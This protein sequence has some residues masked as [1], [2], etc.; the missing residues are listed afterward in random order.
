MSTCITNRLVGK[1]YT[2]MKN[3]GRAHICSVGVCFTMQYVNHIL[4]L[5]FISVLIEPC[6]NQQTSVTIKQGTL[7]GDLKYVAGRA[8]F[9]FLGVPYAEAPIGTLRFQPPIAHPGWQGTYTALNFKP[10]CAQ[11]TGSTTVRDTMSE[12]CLYLN[13]WT[14]S[15]QPGENF[16][17]PVIVLIEG[18]LFT[19]G[20][21]KDTPADDLVSDQDLVVV[22]LAY[23]LNAF[24]FLSFEDDV[25]KG[26]IG[27]MD[28]GLAIQWVYDN[29]EQFGGD[30]NQITLL[31]H[32]AG[33]ASVGYHLISRNIRP[34]INNAIMMSGSLLA[35]WASQKS[36]K[37][38][39]L[40]L[41][42]LLNCP[43]QRSLEL[44]NCLQNKPFMDIV[45]AVNE[46]IKFGNISA[47][48]GPDLKDRLFLSDDPSQALRQGNFKKVPVLTGIMAED[49]VLMGYFIKG[50]LDKIASTEDI[51]TFT[52]EFLLT[53]VLRQYSNIANQVPMRKVISHE[54]IRSLDRLGL[55]TEL[56]DLFTDAYFD[57]PNVQ[58]MN[59]MASAGTEIYYYINDFN[60]VDIFGN[61]L[62]NRSSAAHGT[63][64]LYLLGPTMYKTFFNTDFQAFSQSRF[65]KNLK[66]IIGEF[67]RFGSPESLVLSGQWKLYNMQ[68]KNFYNIYGSYSS[69]DYKQNRAY[70]F[71][72]SYLPYLSSKMFN[73][74]SFN[75]TSPEALLANSCTSFQIATWILLIL[76]LIQV[77]SFIFLL[78]LCIKRYKRASQ[79]PEQS[80]FTVPNAG[81][82]RMQSRS[83]HRQA[84]QSQEVGSLPMRSPIGTSVPNRGKWRDSIS[85]YTG[86]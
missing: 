11:P 8:V 74:E 60:S 64:L 27:L 67:A 24:G 61:N 28:Q 26:N 41:A 1:Y 14:R 45:T 9:Y 66:D 37:D 18:Q 34:F 16:L 7:Q 15:L 39:A 75:A 23:R 47:I 43:S 2:G 83:H 80:I 59:T 31:G 53:Q 57:A 85:E 51:Q 54:Y 17:K 13:V 62:L 76:C 3:V 32:S 35:P 4:L 69:Y 20:N 52:E 68:N 78:L 33:A 77:F 19:L 56:V 65:A 6:H 46:M 49:G 12:D 44:R 25:L 50:R 79:L 71:W 86:S 22:T 5:Y 48:F 63:D 10:P 58:M 73:S 72:T 42:N 38:N 40:I 55:Y 30:P 84:S 81:T 29:I 82:P 21:S 36:P 70:D